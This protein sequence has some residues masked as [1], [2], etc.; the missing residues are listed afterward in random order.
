MISSF[1]L[2]SV[3]IPP[4]PKPNQNQ[5]KNLKSSS[6]PTETPTPTPKDLLDN[7][8]TCFELKQL[9]SYI[10]KTNKDYSIL[11]V[12]RIASICALSP[13]FDYARTI[14]ER[15]EK[16]ETFIWNSCLKTYAESESPINAIH[17][18]YRLRQSNLFP[19]TFTCSFV[20]KA[21]SILLDLHNGRIVHGL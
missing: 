20:L 5:K 17:F 19:D 2:S 3:H 21:C 16:D 18:F 4:L 1:S 8:N 11:P 9:H 7:F 13:C 15:V 6:S 12:T 14:F 10:I